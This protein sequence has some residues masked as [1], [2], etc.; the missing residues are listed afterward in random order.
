[1]FLSQAFFAKKNFANVHESQRGIKIGGKR[2]KVST[3]V[4]LGRHCSSVKEFDKIDKNIKNPRLVF[5]LIQTLKNG[6]IC[7][8]IIFQSTISISK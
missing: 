5:H 2:T 3:E 4:S 6:R 1:M 8:K 7:G